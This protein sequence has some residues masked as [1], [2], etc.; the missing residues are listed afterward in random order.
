LFRS[1]NLQKSKTELMVLCTVRK[2]SPSTEPPAAPHNPEPFL[3]DKKFDPK[4][5]ETKK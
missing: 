5:P 1:K 4:T 3:D 2:I